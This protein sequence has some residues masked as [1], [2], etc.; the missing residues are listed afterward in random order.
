LNIKN[1]P[2]GSMNTIH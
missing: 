1:C 2:L